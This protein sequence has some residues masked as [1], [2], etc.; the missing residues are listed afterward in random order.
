MCISSFNFYH[1]GGHYYRVKPIFQV[2]KLR[3]SEAKW[4]V[5]VSGERGLVAEATFCD[6]PCSQQ[7]EGWGNAEGV[8]PL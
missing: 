3:Y 6:L 1:S 4:S 5:P 2:E 8:S 7:S